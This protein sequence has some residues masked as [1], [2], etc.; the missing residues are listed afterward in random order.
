MNDSGERSSRR[1]K[2]PITILRYRDYRL[3]WA[4]ESVSRIGTQMHSIALSW[5]VYEITGNVALLG[6]LGLVRA[7][8]TM[9]TSLYGG[10]IA[11]TTDR[12][13]LLITTNLILICLSAG[14]ALAT[15]AGFV[16][17]GA[18][19][20]VAALVAAAAAFDQPAR[21]ALIPTLVPRRRI[22]DAMSMNILTGN[23]AQ[24]I[25]PA[26]G[27]FSV[28]VFG[29]AGTYLIDSL[30]FTAVIIALLFMRADTSAPVKIRRGSLATIAEGLKFIRATPVIYGVMLLDFLATILG[31]TISLTPVFA[32][33]IFDAGAQGLGL[34]NSAP[35]VGAVV[36]GA[37]ISLLPS[38]R[39]PGWLII[40]AVAAYGFFLAAFGLSTSLWMGLAFLT[41]YGAADA[42]SMTMRHTIRNLATP[43]ELRGRIA[44]THS[45]FSSGGPRLGEFQTGITASL[46]GVRAT[47]LVGGAG[48]ILVAAGVAWLI[49]AVAR[50]Q[51]DPETEDD[52]EDE[53]S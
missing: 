37:A 38:P 24:M 26:L 41:L 22:P 52:D 2:L 33:E 44:A 20:V 40:S 30:T 48:I 49:P 5:Q 19:Y 42:V 43:D 17:V 11:D 27:G 4:G 47:T 13:R 31:A 29:I 45:A 9:T 53:L 23:A 10:A 46:I 21:A 28:A 18:L 3:I 7:V 14:L 1:R 16:N 6:I 50:Y 25:G 51:F 36:A 8:A 15:Q 12:R 34:L 35:A 39:R 32:E